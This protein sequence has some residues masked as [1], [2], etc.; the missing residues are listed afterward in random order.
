MIRE[1]MASSTW[2]GFCQSVLSQCGPPMEEMPSLERPEFKFKCDVCLIE[3][4]TA[5]K[6]DGIRHMAIQNKCGGRWR[7]LGDGA[8]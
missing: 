7:I 6:L 4:Q 1:P 2:R 3:F 8:K 5:I